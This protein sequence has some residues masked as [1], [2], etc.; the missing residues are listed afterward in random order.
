MSK[1]VGEPEGATPLDPNEMAGLVFKHIQTR[2]QLDEL[3][4]STFRLG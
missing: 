2:G 4:R 1:I 3:D